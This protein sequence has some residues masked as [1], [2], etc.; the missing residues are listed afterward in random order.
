MAVEFCEMDGATLTPSFCF[1]SYA[2]HFNA[3]TATPYFSS[4]KMSFPRKGWRGKRLVTLNVGKLDL[5][6][7]NWLLL[8]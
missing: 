7:R 8:L 4:T 6:L 2:P 1:K 5:L 3:A